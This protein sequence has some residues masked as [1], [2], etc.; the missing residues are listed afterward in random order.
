[1]GFR[2]RKSINLGGGFRVNLSKNGIG[3]SWGVKGY[4]VTKTADGRTRR[5]ASI[6]GTGISYVEEH[7]GGGSAPK[8][9]KPQ[10]D[11]LSEYADVQTVSSASTEKLSSGEY[12][13]LFRKIRHYKAGVT[14]LAIAAFLLISTPPLC[15]VCLAALAVLLMKGRCKITYEFDDFQRERWLEMSEAWKGVASSETLHEIV[16]TAKSKNKR[17]TAGIENGVQTEKMGAGG[18]LPYYLTTNVSP[19]VFAFKD[20]RMAILPDRLLVIEKKKMAAIDY[21]DVKFELSAVGFLESESTPKD[22]EIIE[23][24]WAYA[25]KDGSQDKRYSGNKRYPVMKYGKIVITSDSGLNIQFLC[26]NEKAADKLNDVIGR[27][28][29]Y[30]DSCDS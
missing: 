8:A 4:R 24:V 17:V 1:M 21:H 23:Y 6:P 26:S 3:Y 16:L 27:R 10:I 15:V 28:P 22:S 9:E 25:N 14:V 30:S 11:P 5:T 20:K 29:E 2:Y 12:G 7:R 13:Q 18:R 19:V